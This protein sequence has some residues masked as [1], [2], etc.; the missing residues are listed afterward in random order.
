LRSETVARAHLAPALGA[1][2]GLL[3]SPFF[4]IEA[5]G[6]IRMAR[7]RFYMLA[8]LILA[9]HHRAVG[10]WVMRMAL[11]VLFTVHGLLRRSDRNVSI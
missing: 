11:S 6:E 3:A 1:T 5:G 8:A 2:A 4:V 7:S 10:R 9:F